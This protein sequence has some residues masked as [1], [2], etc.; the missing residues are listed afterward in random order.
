LYTDTQRDRNVMPYVY[1][2]IF[3]IRKVGQNV[4]VSIVCRKCFRWTF[5][6]CSDGK[7]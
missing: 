3:K 2:Y 1:V 6:C 4:N 5:H 7:N